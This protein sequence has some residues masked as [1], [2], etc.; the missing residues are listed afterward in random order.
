MKRLS[1]DRKSLT[2]HHETIC[3]VFH[4]L[5]HSASIE[6]IKIIIALCE[7]IGKIHLSKQPQNNST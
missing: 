3:K 2:C 6:P 5:F 7:F 1:A 4:L